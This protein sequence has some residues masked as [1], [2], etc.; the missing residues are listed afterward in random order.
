MR[1]RRFRERQCHER[2]LD[3]LARQ[4]AEATTGKVTSGPFAGMILNYELLPTHAG[5]TFLGTLEKELHW[6][7]EKAI[8]LSPT[9]VLNI[10]CAEGYY[11]I[12]LALRL[13]QAKVFA[14]ET[15]PKSL[16]ATRRNAELNGV[17]D[18]VQ[19]IR[20][21]KPGQFSKYLQANSSFIMMDCEGCEF[22]LLDPHNDP[23]L[24]RADILVEIHS[25]HGDKRQIMAKFRDTHNVT[26]IRAV[27]RTILDAPKWV[28]GL[29]V[30]S[31]MDEGRS[32]DQRW[33]FLQLKR[34]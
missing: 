28:R 6:A 3:R 15:D 34:R 33:L 27:P 29:D 5:C 8:N 20:I 22:G 18:R 17:S 21:I 11:A 24:L 30:L 2:G 31:A 9:R 12:G 1:S 4:V 13:P 7:I 26:E 14:A 10:G 16:C 32:Q 23:I 19:P 25:E